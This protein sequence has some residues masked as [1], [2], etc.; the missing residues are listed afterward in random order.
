[1]LWGAVQAEQCDS[2]VEMFVRC[3]AVHARSVIREHARV[4]DGIGR[5]WLD[6]LDRRLE[7]L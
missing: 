6:A 2:Y 5:V 1:M 4:D 7:V 3:G